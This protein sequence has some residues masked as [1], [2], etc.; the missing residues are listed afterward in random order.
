[1]PEFV[2]YADLTGDVRE[3]AAVILE[4]GSGESSKKEVAVLSESGSKLVHVAS[5]VLGHA[6]VSDIRAQQGV[7][8][9]K[10]K[11]QLPGDPGPRTTEFVFVVKKP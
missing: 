9:V 10:A 5:Y 11:H 7:V 6:D 2:T 8:H 1:M 3:D 4:I